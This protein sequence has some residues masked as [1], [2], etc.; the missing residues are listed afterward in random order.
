MIL[1][2]RHKFLIL[3]I[4]IYMPYGQS[5]IDY[6]YLLI[7]VL[8]SV[9]SHPNR[10]YTHLSN[11]LSWKEFSLCS[12]HTLHNLID[13][14]FLIH[15]FISLWNWNFILPSP[16]HFK[17]EITVSFLHFDKTL[18]TLLQC[19]YN[20]QLHYIQT[21]NLKFTATIWVIFWRLLSPRIPID[22]HMINTF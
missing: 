9:F 20:L 22:W 3:I 14:I 6:C 7:D 10:S 5:H 15:H 12:S 1:S 13:F 4:F 21:L 11:C 19:T 18:Y 17:T 2:W 8:I 16:I